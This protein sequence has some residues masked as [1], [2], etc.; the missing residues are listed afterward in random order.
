[1]NREG[2]KTS[3]VNAASRTK[4]RSKSLMIWA[5]PGL[6]QNDT[7]LILRVLEKLKDTEYGTNKSVIQNLHSS[8]QGCEKCATEG[9]DGLRHEGAEG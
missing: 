7:L 8:E 6:R 2:D 5:S 1:M 4:E 3:G 9:A